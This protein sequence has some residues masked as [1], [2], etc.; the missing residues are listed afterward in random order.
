MTRSTR[1][2]GRIS[3]RLSLFWHAA[4]AVSHAAQPSLTLSGGSGSPGGSVNVSM[5][6][7]ANGTQA[8][9]AGWI[10]NYSS[11][12]FSSVTITASP[13]VTSVSGEVL[14][15]STGA[16]SANC[17]VINLS[18]S[19]VLVPNGTLAVATFHISPTTKSTS[20]SI[21]LSSLSATDGGGKSLGLSGSGASVTINQPIPPPALSGLT[22]VP[23]TLTP[24]GSS[25]CTVSLAGAATSSMS[26]SLSSGNPAVTVP[27][28]ATIGTGTT[29]TTFTAN[30]AAAVSATA[31]AVLTA[32][33]SGSS[34]TATLTLNPQAPVLSSLTCA[35][36]VFTPPGS[37]TCT[38]S[39]TNPASSPAT[40][41]LSSGSPAVGLPAL[42]K[43]GAGV[44]SA[45]FTATAPSAVGANTSAL[46]TAVLSGSFKTATLTLDAPAPPVLSSL[47]CAPGT[48]TPPGNSTCTVS[49]TNVTTSA[50]SVNLSSGNAAVTVPASVAIG[51]GASSATF[52]ANAAAAVS[53]TGSAL[54][55][56]TWNGTSKTTTLTLS[57]P[58]PA[59][60]SLSC[61]P[62][63]F[64]PPGNST[65]TVSLASAATSPTSVSLSSG[66]AAVTVPAS[67]TIGTGTTSATFIANA[68]TAVN[69]SAAVLLMAAWNGTSQTFS[70]NLSANQ[71]AQPGV[72][73]LVCNPTSLVGGGIVN[74]T[75]T[76]NAAAP[77]GGTPVT[78]SSSS[79]SLTPPGQVTVVAGSLSAAFAVR[80][81]AVG[82][83]QTP[84]LTAASSSG[85]KTAT[86]TLQAGAANA[87]LVCS[88]ASV[89]T[90][91]SST[92]TI[93]LASLAPTDSSFSLSSSSASV[94]VPPSVTIGTGMTST[95]FA[96]QAAAVTLQ[97]T[98]VVSAPGA[99]SQSLTL[100]PPPGTSSSQP[101]LSCSPST[102]TGGG[103]AACTLTL[104]AAAPTGGVGVQVLSSSSQIT[105]PSIVQIAGGT[106]TAQFTAATPVIDH[107][108]N[109]TISAA[110]QNSSMR[111]SI[112]LVGLK[113]VSL[114]CS[115]KTAVAGSQVIC[116]VTLNSASATGTA[117]VALSSSDP[118]LTPPSSISTQPGQAIAQF[119][120][121]T[122][123]VAQT[124]AVTISAT[125]H[126]VAVQGTVTL[127]PTGPALTVPGTQSV[128]TGK[129]LNFAVS[130]K[131]P[132]GTPAA[133]GASGLPANAWFDPNR[134]TF[135]WVPTVSQIG[136]H[137]VHFMATDAAQATSSADVIIN[138]E[139]ETPTVLRVVNAASN[140]DDGGC[141]P[142][143]IVTL[144][145]GSFTHAPQQSAN[146]SPLPTTLSGAR[147]KANGEYLPLLYAA[148]FQLNVQCPQLAPGASL[149]LVVED[150]NGSSSPLSSTMQYAT[151]GIFTLDGSGTGQGAIVTANTNTLAMPHVD[152]LPSRPAKAGD[153]ISIYATGLGPVSPSLPSGQPTPLDS[154]ILLTPEA[155]VLINGLATD[156]Q[157]AGM[158]PGYVGVYQVNAKIPPKT[159]PS[160]AVSVQIVVHLPDGTGALSNVVTI[161]VAAAQ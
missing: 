16:G 35:P 14:S 148:E 129:P 100:L 96:A 122:T 23:N 32:T 128:Q 5:T 31:S 120:A 125:L 82:T 154:S 44:T 78:I 132:S 121:N 138:V 58:L 141:S 41:S 116:Q 42:I 80:T 8:T 28:S 105:V 130:A 67:V 110:M 34:Q 4:V 79:S 18:S 3:A 74:C 151:P 150:S 27:V 22:C 66:N 13:T 56:A 140:V 104:P 52:T 124:E 123:A 53:T 97:S 136:S 49:L 106:S 24:P 88:P 69:A 156:V 112:V 65:C 90:P 10:L 43:I 50:A 59:L 36:S 51:T 155:D 72:A 57:A 158:A 40:V 25:T 127:A 11:T 1:W 160:N 38:V 108:E 47:T 73:S 126:G 75:V 142:G 135:S 71:V 20:S 94:S 7:N 84:T 117:A 86:I 91:G 131:D 39:L 64:T 139:S 77:A 89:Q 145:G 37:S 144:S 101:A 111:T 81:Q 99:G 19:S 114:S 45:T 159:A 83:T 60:S 29:S 6:F 103:Y 15:C 95:T 17:L 98:V 118:H 61:T 92:C 2:C 76:L 12:D 63:T 30:A 102:L 46:L 93:T 68:A 26:V 48:F 85:G 157:F 133:L 137:T 115:P 21:S 113:P 119:V 161:A 62:G 143:G 33:L 9:G 107:D 87:S 147:V 55:T 149:T 134:G 54:L 146:V 153:F 152:S 109:V 70:L